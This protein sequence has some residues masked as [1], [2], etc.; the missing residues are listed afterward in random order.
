MFLVVCVYL[1]LCF[2]SMTNCLETVITR[3]LLSYVSTME[4]PSILIPMNQYCG[5]LGQERTVFEAVNI[6]AL[7]KDSGWWLLRFHGCFVKKNSD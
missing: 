7:W 4:I 2:F 5:C 1:S 6:V 3:I